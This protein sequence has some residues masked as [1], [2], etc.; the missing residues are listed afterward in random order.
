MPVTARGR[1]PGTRSPRFTSAKKAWRLRLRLAGCGGEGPPS[2]GGQWLP[3][4]ADDE[5][6]VAL[7]DR[8]HLD[9][10]FSPGGD[11]VE[12]GL[13]RVVDVHLGFGDRIKDHLRRRKG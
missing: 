10:E 4:G 12:V 11:R 6:G 13:E 5:Q 9:D 7:D 3:F 2:V 8:G 1:S